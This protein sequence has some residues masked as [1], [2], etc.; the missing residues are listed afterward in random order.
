MSNH[1]PRQDKNQ[2]HLCESLKVVALKGRVFEVGE[3]PAP[4]LLLTCTLR[5]KDT[6]W[7]EEEGVGGGGGGSTRGRHPV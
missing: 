6:I 7:A 5:L 2:R 1:K 3:T 4:Q